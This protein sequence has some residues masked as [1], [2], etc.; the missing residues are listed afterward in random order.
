M[1][2]LPQP[3]KNYVRDKKEILMLVNTTFLFNT[4]ITNWRTQR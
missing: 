4:L 2:T 3:M 1:A